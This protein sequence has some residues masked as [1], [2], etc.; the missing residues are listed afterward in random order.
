MFTGYSSENES[1]FSE[2]TILSSPERD[3]CSSNEEVD[4]QD[5]ERNN[6]SNHNLHTQ[7]EII[8][9]SDDHSDYNYHSSSDLY[10]EDSCPSLY[11]DN[12]S[13]SSNQSAMSAS[14]TSLS[15]TCIELSM[16]GDPEELMMDV[17]STTNEYM[18]NLTSL[19]SLAESTDES[20]QINS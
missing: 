20:V 19:S 13:A 4:F 10:N 6:L 5:T 18:E 17:Q 2:T 7:N 11:N 8:N 3:F 1:L 12:S 16:N 14:N 15:D 9:D